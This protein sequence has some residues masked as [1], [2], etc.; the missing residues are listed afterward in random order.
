MS[1]RMI[2]IPFGS[3]MERVLSDAKQGHVLGVR[4][5]FR[6][7]AGKRLPLFG[8]RPETPIGPA[9]G[10]HTQLAQNIIAAYAGGARFFELKTVQT[11]DGEDL[12]V[13]KPCIYA[14]DEC[15]NVEWSTE[16]RVEEALGE[17]VKAWFALKLLSR[18]LGLGEPDGFTFNMSVG[19]SYEGITSPK[20]DAFIEGLKDARNTPAWSE[21]VRWTRENLSRFERVDRGYID[22]V[23]SRVCTSATLSTLHGCPP[24]EIERI[25][26]YLLTE[27]KLHTFVKCN[28]TLLGYD[29]CRRTLDALGFDYVAFDDAHFR[30]DLQYAD[31]VPMFTRLRE[32][33]DRLGLEFGLKLSNTFPVKILRGE[34]PGEEMYMSGRA[35]YPLTLEMVRRLSASF[36][37]TM[38]LSYSGGADERTVRA[39]FSA[40]IRPITL[41]T[42]L[43]KPG[44]YDRLYDMAAGLYACPYGPFEGVS[45][46]E[47]EKLAASV[48]SDPALQKP[49]KPERAAR[50]PGPA[51]LFGCFTAPCSGSCP[52]GQDIPAY[53]ALAGEGRYAE[54]LSVILRRNPLPFIT[55]T[56]CP[57]TCQG[58]CTRRFYE[59]SVHI[60]ET[61]LLAAENGFETCLGA[62]EPKRASGLRAVVV[63]GG[64]AG[65]A[66]AFLLASE[67]VGVTLYEREAKLG[68]IVRRTIPSFRIG[69]DR[70]DRDAAFLTKL[71]VD[72]RTGTEAPPLKEL[73]KEYGAVVYAV[74]AHVPAELSLEEGEAV[75]ALRFLTEIKSG[76]RMKGGP[77]AVIVGAGN[78]AMDAARAALR[79]EGVEDVAIVY[80]RTRREMP[81]DGEELELALREGVRFVELASPVRLSGGVL[82]VGRMRLGEPDGSGRRRPEPTGE[83][84]TLPCDLLV[85]AL[86]E[87]ADAEFFRAQGL[88][89][90][91]KGFPVLDPDALSA[92]EPGVWVIGDAKAGPATVVKAIADAHAAVNAILRKD[93][94]APVEDY[95]GSRGSSESKQGRILPFV[96]AGSEKERCLDCA[97]AC[98]CCVQVCP[99]RANVSIPL[100]GFAMPVVLH[101]DDLCNACGNCAE[102]CP[103]DSAPYR[104]KLTL[105]SGRDAFEEG[106]A[107]LLPLGN[108]RWL[109][110]A[111][112]EARETS[113]GSEPDARLKALLTALEG[114]YRF[115]M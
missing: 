86:G 32:T 101:L 69:E 73:K 107:G 57:H 90:G 79:L 106:G 96:S 47:L 12:P 104:D 75:S 62:L 68:G 65:M 46:P 22:S 37:G 24:G 20:I 114:P 16:L 83:T 4:H 11:L 23:P 58:A 103:Y 71:G 91:A 8:E 38:R 87:T 109:V 115:L 81:A 49:L 5:L 59:D 7:D 40:G 26:S 42:A 93:P 61:K 80:R 54:A 70:I 31:A 95:P 105:F 27:K 18:E 17:Y 84:E 33:A 55:G 30:G 92:S 67:G 44:G 98:E 77:H 78:T 48:L 34:L 51:P 72:V 76:E 43:L 14:P 35:L 2:P 52:I 102:F 6:A 99:N 85:A 3:L 113:A 111:G 1:D 13:S 50:L 56:I 9:A 82:T 36:G 108:G 94:P 45:L 63:G 39:L 19:Y 10:P 15:Y 89:V 112:G 97:R 88:A 64:P 110:R 74:G 53:V 41:A 25:A 29:F 28:P 66:A 60:R 100:P 21:C